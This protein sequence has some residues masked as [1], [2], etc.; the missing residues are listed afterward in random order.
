MILKNSVFKAFPELGT[1]KRLLYE[2]G[3]D[4]AAMSGSGST[5]FGIY[6]QI[7]Q[8]EKTGQ[9]LDGDFKIAYPVG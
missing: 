9:L 1:M 4:Y 5:I 3:A 7:E 8:A 6:S 2:N